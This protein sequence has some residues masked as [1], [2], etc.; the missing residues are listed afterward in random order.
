MSC[1]NM[2]YSSLCNDVMM[3]NNNNISRDSEYH[4][5]RLERFCQ[6]Q[7]DDPICSKLSPIC[8]QGGPAN[9]RY[10]TLLNSIGQSV[11]S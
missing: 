5:E 4:T 1:I 6:Q 10:H 11:E 3:C 7:A 8:Q 2:Y 9:T